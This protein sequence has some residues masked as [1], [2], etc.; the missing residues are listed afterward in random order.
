MFA[1]NWLFSLPI[2]S[3][4]LQIRGQRLDLRQHF[5][6]VAAVFKSQI[7]VKVV[8]PFFADDGQG[9]DFVEIYSARGNDR[10]NS[11][12]TSGQMSRPKAN[13]RFVKIGNFLTFTAPA[14]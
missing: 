6:I 1:L 11:R 5:S 2:F 3:Q 9:L 7:N 14:Q 4:N 10:Q 13:R 8:L 12:Q